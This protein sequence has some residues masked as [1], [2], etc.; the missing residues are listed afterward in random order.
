MIR[1]NHKDRLFVKLF[2][3]SENKQNLLSLYNALN[4]R[5]YTDPD[6]LEINTIENVIYMG[7]KNDVSCIIDGHINL[8]EHQGSFSPNMPLRGF[9]YLPKLYE[10]YIIKHE[11]NIYSEKL[12]KIPTPKYFVLFNYLT[13]T[14][15]RS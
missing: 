15:C 5:N 12:I 2:G 13:K 10:K 1:R 11:L 3:D 7:V 14:A 8:M 6:E 4:G 9:I